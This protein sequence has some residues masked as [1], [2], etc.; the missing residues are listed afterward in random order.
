MTTDW[1]MRPTRGKYDR[2]ATGEAT[3]E[4][5]S[6]LPTRTL[7]V[8]HLLCTGMY[9]ILKTPLCVCTFALG[10]LLLAVEKSAFAMAM[11]IVGSV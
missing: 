9:N 1:L 7:R 5:G 4:G 10:F 3:N 2:P 8:S 11:K 6:M